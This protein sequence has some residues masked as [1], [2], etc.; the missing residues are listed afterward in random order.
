MI[1]GTSQNKGPTD[2]HVILC[3]PEPFSSIHP[4]YQV[5]KAAISPGTTLEVVRP[6]LE[7][8]GSFPLA[9]SGHSSDAEC[10]VVWISAD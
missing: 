6:L 5:G 10:Q 9:S 4:L 8:K 2:S 1:Q 7:R 3:S